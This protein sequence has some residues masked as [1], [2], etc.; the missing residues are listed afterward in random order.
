MT[1]PN[2]SRQHTDHPGWPNQP[3]DDRWQ[4]HP[5]GS[6]PEPWPGAQRVEH[7]AQIPGSTWGQ[8]VGAPGPAAAIPPP[9][10]RRRTASTLLGIAAALSLITAAVFVTLY[11]TE[12]SNHGNTQREFSSQQQELEGMRGKL[13]ASEEK[14]RFQQN[15]IAELENR[16]AELR[17]CAE[18]TTEFFA[19]LDADDDAKIDQALSDMYQTC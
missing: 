12:R 2:D 8:P 13:N 15:R 16:N 10:P 5:A 14:E 4:H 17:E 9:Q 3:T 18:V 7:I 11:L 1:G 19:A 6:A